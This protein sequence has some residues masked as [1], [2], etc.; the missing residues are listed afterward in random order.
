MCRPARGE[1]K[2][3]RNVEN[4]QGAL[5]RAGICVGVALG[6]AQGYMFRGAAHVGGG[7]RACRRGGYVHVQA[8]DLS[9]H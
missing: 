8:G 5:L 7:V 2:V 9:F 3:C 6:A 1:T 4:V